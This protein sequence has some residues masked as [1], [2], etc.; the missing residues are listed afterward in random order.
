MFQA[1]RHQPYL[2]SEVYE[3]FV[4]DT[5]RTTPHLRFMLIPIMARLEDLMFDGV[6]DLAKRGE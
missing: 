1:W 5:T 3:I 4:G 2:E 6:E